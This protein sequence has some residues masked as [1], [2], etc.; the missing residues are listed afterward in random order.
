MHF[1]GLPFFCFFAALFG[2]V[3]CPLGLGGA[4]RL[5]N[6]SVCKLASIKGLKELKLLP[7]S[8]LWCIFELAAYKK[9]GLS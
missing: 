3:L 7:R 4:F 2:V 5:S 8:R 6:C 9:V 1:L